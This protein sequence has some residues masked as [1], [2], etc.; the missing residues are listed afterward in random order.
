MVLRLVVV[1]GA[2]SGAFN[3]FLFTR[4]GYPSLFVFF[5]SS[6]RR[7]TRFSRDWSSDVCSPISQVTLGLL[8]HR[9]PDV[10]VDGMRAVHRGLRIADDAQLCAGAPRELPRLLD[11]A[12]VRSVALRARDGDVE[13]GER[14]RLQ[15]RMGDVVAS[16]ADECKP[17]LFEIPERLPHRQDVGE[18]L[19]RVVLVRER[20]D[21]RHRSPLCERLDRL[22]R[23]RADHDRIDV[24]GQRTGGVGD[25]LAPS[26]LELLWRERDRR[27]AE[28][29]RSRGEGNPGP[30]RRLFE[31]AGDRPPSQ[32]VFATG[33]VILHRRGEVQ[34]LREPVRR[35]IRDA[36]EVAEPRSGGEGV[37][38]R[39]PTTTGSG[40]A[41][42]WAT[43]GSSTSASVGVPT[44]SSSYRTWRIGW[45]EVMRRPRSIGVP[46]TTTSQSAALIVASS[47]ASCCSPYPIAGR[48]FVSCGQ[49]SNVSLIDPTAK[50]RGSTIFA[51]PAFR[52][53]TRPA[54]NGI[55]PCVSVGPSSTTR[56]YRPSRSGP[57]SR[58]GGDSAKM[59]VAMGLTDSMFS[60]TRSTLCAS[61]ESTLL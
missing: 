27:G 2:F 55:S 49:R 54:P 1:A 58:V 45:R 28:P 33:L 25:R 17:P 20:V 37:H 14:A 29:R 53:A 7:H 48:T 23:E 26:E 31:D 24:A 12:C 35:Q 44:S 18:R 16:V 47:S 41:V 40:R 52:A 50:G 42:A 56:T 13:T 38:R 3:G 30:R 60:S 36:R 57:S 10:C 5:F 9:G 11:D 15:Q 21:H 61:A 19:A 59:T 4:L 43:I 22:L 8:A 51:A 32:F 39:H 46:V 34:E 6:R